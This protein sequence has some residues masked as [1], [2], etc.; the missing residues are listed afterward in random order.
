MRK[1]LL[2]ILLTNFAFSCSEDDQNNPS[3]NFNDANRHQNAKKENVNI[4]QMKSYIKEYTDLS[5]LLPLNP[6]LNKGV[7]YIE[8]IDSTNITKIS[9]NGITTFTLFVNTLDDEFYNY[10]N[11]IFCHKKKL[12]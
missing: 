12:D 7:D 4:Q 2:F 11:L 8:Y 3:T 6:E 9:Y 10:S 5:F 1:I